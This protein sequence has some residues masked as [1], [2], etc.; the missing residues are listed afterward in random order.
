MANTT[1]V[2]ATGTFQTLGSEVTVNEDGIGSATLM[3]YT[4]GSG[5]VR[6]A[7]SMESHPD[8]SWLKRK[9][10]K[11]TDEEGGVQKIAATFEGVPPSDNKSGGGG[12][13]SGGTT[14]PKYSLKTVASSAP[15][16]DH[17]NFSNWATNAHLTGCSIDTDEGP[18]K[19]KFIGFVKKNTVLQSR[20][21][22]VT[23]FYTPQITF[24]ET[25]LYEGS[26][27]PSSTQADMTRVGLVDTPPQIVSSF[28]KVPS[29]FNWLLTGCD[30]EQVGYG[31]K[32][33]KTWLLSVN[34]LGWNKYIYGT[35]GDG[36]VS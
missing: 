6:E 21:Y 25:A 36:N 7:L 22:G 24:Q 11:I 29:G 35:G 27:A 8:Y 19:G 31:V 16:T 13:G 32:V 4:T 18:N 33:T 3:Y 15:I 2:G 30:S 26:K 20:F 34:A 17:P 10:I 9:S 28:I 23:S 1:I 14:I 12:S 5:A